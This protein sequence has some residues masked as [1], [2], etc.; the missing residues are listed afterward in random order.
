MRVK[1]F[2]QSFEELTP[3][4]QCP[5]I[6]NAKKVLRFNCTYVKMFTPFSGDKEPEIM[7]HMFYEPLPGR[8]RM[9]FFL[10]VLRPPVILDV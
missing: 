10:C 7:V 1:R 4:D 6:F 3:Q 8:C 5:I 2:T 9:R